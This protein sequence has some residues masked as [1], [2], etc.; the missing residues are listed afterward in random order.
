[1]FLVALARARI[2]K[3]TKREKRDQH[4][5]DTDL[6]NLIVPKRY[7]MSRKSLVV[8]L[9]PAKRLGV[10]LNADGLHKETDVG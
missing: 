8:G 10:H 2:Q 3:A 4:T 6:Y 5:P 9:I 7:G 1:M